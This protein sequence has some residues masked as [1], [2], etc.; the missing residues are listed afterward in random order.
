MDFVRE[1]LTAK[2]SVDFG[3]SQERPNNI[4]LEILADTVFVKVHCTTVI[5]PLWNT[6]VVCI[7]DVILGKI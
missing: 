3:D 5:S 1:H 7:G 4:E 2:K 6:N